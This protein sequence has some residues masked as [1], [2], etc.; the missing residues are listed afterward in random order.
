MKIIVFCTLDLFVQ[1]QDGVGMQN[2]TSKT[3]F[4]LT[5]LTETQVTGRNVLPHTVTQT[6]LGPSSPSDS[7]VP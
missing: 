6:N 5:T 4:P 7:D 3:S 1:D 2:R